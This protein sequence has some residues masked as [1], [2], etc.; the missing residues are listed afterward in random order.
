[1]RQVY[2]LGHRA[3]FDRFLRVLIFKGNASIAD[4]VII[5]DLLPPDTILELATRDDCSLIGV[6]HLILEVKTND[7][8]VHKVNFLSRESTPGVWNAN[9]IIVL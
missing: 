3:A 6:V 7:R 1:M 5:V 2:H 9:G 8:V 4:A